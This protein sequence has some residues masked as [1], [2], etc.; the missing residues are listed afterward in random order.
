ME[1]S[2]DVFF[3][4][5]RHIFGVCPNP[6]CRE[7]SRL[8]DIR[9]SYRAKYVQDW[10]DRVEDQ[11]ASWEDKQEGLEEKQKEL[12]AKYIEKARK[13]VLPQKLRTISSLFQKRLVQPEDIKVV[14]HPLDFIA[15]DGL[16]T[17]EDLQRVVLLDSESSKKFRSGIQNS[18]RTTVENGKYDWHIARVDEE[19]KV[20][21]E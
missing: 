6:E 5:Q 1:T 13:T 14:S 15:F 19:G 9:V 3:K 2:F 11:M 21:L 4:E 7:V 10:L 20:T 17:N 16:I 18:I 8:A 12:K